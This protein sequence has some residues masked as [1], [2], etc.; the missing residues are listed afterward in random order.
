MTRQT[1]PVAAEDTLTI[2]RV[3]GDVTVQGW[4]Q[5][6]LQANG[7][8]IHIE[9][10]E[11]SIL[12]TGAGDLSLS[13]PRGMRVSLKSIG[14]DATLQDLT[15]AV[16]LRLV[17]G[18]ANLRNLS[19]SV[20]LS[21][22]IGGETHLENVANVSMSSGGVDLGSDISERLQ[23][24]IRQA[25]ERAEKK[26]RRAHVDHLSRTYRVRFDKG[27]LDYNSDSAASAAPAGE[28]VAEEERMMILRMLQEKKITSEEANKLLS[29]LEGNA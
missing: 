14:G 27:G 25:T 21:G 19:G 15:G 22:V 5:Q 8:V 3:G 6:E 17:G 16:D 1:I 13:I 11:R 7:D 26:L 18:D 28:P 29:A 23:R 20:Q 2:D 12:I 4:D 9:R 10:E 24:K